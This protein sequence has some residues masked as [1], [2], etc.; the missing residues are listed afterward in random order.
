M[1]LPTITTFAACQ[2]LVY[3]VF[4]LIHLQKGKKVNNGEGRVLTLLTP[5]S[6]SSGRGLEQ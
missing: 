4:I 1:N 5:G 3:C 6:H 2:V